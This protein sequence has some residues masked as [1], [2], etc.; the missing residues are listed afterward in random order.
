MR[1]AAPFLSELFTAAGVR[2]LSPARL[3]RVLI[4]SLTDDSRKVK[5]GGCFVAVR[6]TGRDGHDYLDA[7]VKSGASVA[8]IEQEVAV[9][10]PT[11]A[12]KVADTH[13]AVAKL[14]AAFYGLRNG[15]QRPMTLIGVTGTNGKST[16]VW[17]LRS[18]FRAGGMPCALIGT[19][20]YDLLTERLP[21]PLTTPNPITLCEHLALAR[22]RGAISAVLEVSSHALDQRRCDGL[23]FAAGV[24]TNLS[25]EHLDYHQ[26]MEQYGASKRRLFGLLAPD[27]AAVINLDDPTGREMADD[28]RGH[29]VHSFGLEGCD[30]EVRGVAVETDSRGSR[31][32][33][34]GRRFE[35]RVRLA[36]VGKHNISN[37]LAAAAAAESVGVDAEA[38]RTGLEAVKFVPG[39]L[40]RAEPDGW[41]FSVFVDYAH[42]DAALAS[43]LD[44][45]RP[46]TK[47]RI[48]CVFGCGGDRDRT[49]R[50][51][52]AAAVGRLADVAF[53][54]SDNPRMESPRGIIDE[55]LPGFGKGASCQV[56][57]ESDRRGAINMAVAEARPGDT[58]LIAG[59]GHEN[60]Q[61]VGDKVLAFDD[62]V[63]AREC[64]S[65]LAARGTAA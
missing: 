5:P 4:S 33:I 7:A 31:F 55:I 21:A 58:V 45:I 47:G 15:A 44:A 23:N 12:V 35:T 37:A 60:Y 52:M 61:L 46:I 18:I 43:V 2:A 53:V 29:R 13:E 20:E 42:T 30:A 34:R 17:L 50:P 25:G 11:L 63:V 41:P 24:F 22:D 32:V 19:I 10:P 62:L 59:K 54:T 36:L 9:A 39:R 16:V 49:K 8:I 65:R 26:T 56:I 64:L 1:G 14:A 51:R 57:V 40:H 6:G 27:A 28:L 3:P 48:L 38:I